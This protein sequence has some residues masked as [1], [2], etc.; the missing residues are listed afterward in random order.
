MSENITTPG[1]PNGL[2]LCA[3]CGAVYPVRRQGDDWRAIGTDGACRCGEDD[4]RL[5]QAE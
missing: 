4:F 2:G 5:M 3:S 1:T